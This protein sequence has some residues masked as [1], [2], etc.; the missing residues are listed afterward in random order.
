MCGVVKQNG[1]F[2]KHTTVSLKPGHQEKE[3]VH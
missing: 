2:L 3:V 1:D